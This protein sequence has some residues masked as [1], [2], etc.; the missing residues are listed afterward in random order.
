MLGAAFRRCLVVD[1]SQWAGCVVSITNQS[2]G[3]LSLSNVTTHVFWCA[4]QAPA[5]QVRAESKYGV[6][7]HG[8][9][10]GS[11]SATLRSPHFPSTDVWTLILATRCDNTSDLLDRMSTSGSVSLWCSFHWKV[12]N[13]SGRQHLASLAR[14]TSGCVVHVNANLR[15]SRMCIFSGL[16]LNSTHSCRLDLRSGSIFHE[17]CRVEC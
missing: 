9:A 5:V 4:M 10:F 17:I 13:P 16:S 2:H 15:V 14:N 11:S 12:I 1:L 3:R 8:F 6:S 7:P